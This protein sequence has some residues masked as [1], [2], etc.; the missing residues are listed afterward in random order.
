MVSRRNV[1][2]LGLS[3][4]SLIV[5]FH[6]QNCAPA[7]PAGLT[8]RA[9]SDARLI[10]DFNKSEIQFVTPEVQLHDE[11]VSADISG[12]CNRSHNGAAL[13][14]SLWSSGGDVL[15]RGDS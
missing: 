7:R 15:A 14:W 10:D 1:T 4:L 12:L 9:G 13:R 5:L 8:G 6:F 3:V 11:A 2:I